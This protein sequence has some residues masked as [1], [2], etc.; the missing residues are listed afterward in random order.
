MEKWRRSRRTLLMSP[1]AW[2][3][4]RPFIRTAQAQTDAIKTPRCFVLMSK[5]QGQ[6]AHNRTDT[7]LPTMGANGLTLPTA[8]SPFEPVKSSLNF[9]C[10]YEL[11]AMRM[12]MGEAVDW[13]HSAVTLFNGG[14][15]EY[16]EKRGDD[17]VAPATF[18][19]LDWY[20]AKKWNTTPLNFQPLCRPGD[21]PRKNGDRISWRREPRG[22]TCSAACSSRRLAGRRS[23]TPIR[24]PPPSAPRR[25]RASS[26][27]RAP[28]APR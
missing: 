7:W 22:P 11:H 10:G 25:W 27:R 19:S 15:L 2:L 12:H 1:A 24:S 28:T 8:L 16:P 23:R 5:S 4:L 18:E 9:L 17:N 26:T 21:P 6:Y 3:L 20:V 13:H 14:L